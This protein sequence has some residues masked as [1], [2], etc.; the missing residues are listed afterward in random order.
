MLRHAALVAVLAIT[1]LGAAVAQEDPLAGDAGSIAFDPEFEPWQP[2][3]RTFPERAMDRSASGV[4]HLC[5]RAREDRT[6]DCSVGYETTERFR[7]GPASLDLLRNFRL[8]PASYAELQARQT[9]TMRIPIRWQ[10]TPIP[11]NMDEVVQRIESATE[12]LCGPGT[13]IDA[14][15]YIEI[16]ASSQRRR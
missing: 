10:T 14:N 5:C 3:G 12:N 7:F 11:P 15:S 2:T 13:S 16:S 6:L 8:T 9:Q 1:L 4:V